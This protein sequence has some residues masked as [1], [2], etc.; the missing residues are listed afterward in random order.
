LP[1]AASGTGRDGEDAL[2][3]VLLLGAAGRQPVARKAR[4]R[5]RGA[6]GLHRQ[7]RQLHLQTH[8]LLLCGAE[9]GEFLE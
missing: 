9:D 7:H 3:P 8:G 2:L 1:I 6:G 4:P 5:A